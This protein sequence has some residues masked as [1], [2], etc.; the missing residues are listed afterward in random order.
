M[1]ERATQEADSFVLQLAFLY[2]ELGEELS[3][4][5]D[6]WLIG[7]LQLAC[8]ECYTLALL[9]GTAG[10]ASGSNFGESLNSVADKLRSAF[11][12]MNKHITEHDKLHLSKK[13]GALYAANLAA[14]CMFKLQRMQQAEYLYRPVTNPSFPPLHEF[15]RSQQVTYRFYCGRLALSSGNLA[16]ANEHLSYAAK[17]C[18]RSSKHNAQLI[19]RYLVPVRMSLGQLPLARLLEKHG[20]AEY[21]ELS[22]AMR[23]GDVRTFV[24][25][26]DTFQLQYIKIGVFLLIER[27]TLVVYRRLLQRLRLVLGSKHLPLPAI[28]CA[29]KSSGVDFTQEEVHCIV[30][31]LVTEKLMKCQISLS[32]NI[33]LMPEHAFPPLKKKKVQVGTHS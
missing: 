22:Q 32:S 13:W 9:S 27:L 29:F 2:R 4:A 14:K 31:R 10:E 18:H 12:S 26:K 11:Q 30:A 19:M 25:A 20:L 7:P 5:Y 15:P 16:A 33:V 6:N 3:S 28:E 17:H 24:R 8:N 21:A 23:E 1:S